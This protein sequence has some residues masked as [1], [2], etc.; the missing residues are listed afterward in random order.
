MITHKNKNKNLLRI[1]L[2][3]QSDE[4]TLLLWSKGLVKEKYQKDD[5]EP[6]FEDYR[7]RSDYA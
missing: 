7:I 3:C 6:R 4:I 5:Q 1:L 2:K